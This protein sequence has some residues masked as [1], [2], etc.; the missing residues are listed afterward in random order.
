MVIG[1][2]NMITVQQETSKSTTL[3][4]S[5]GQWLWNSN[6]S[7]ARNIEVYYFGQSCNYVSP[8]A[9]PYNPLLLLSIEITPWATR[10]PP[11]SHQIWNKRTNEQN[12]KLPQKQTFGISR[13]IRS[14][15]CQKFHQQYKSTLHKQCMPSSLA[16]NQNIAKPRYLAFHFYSAGQSI[17]SRLLIN[18]PW[19]H[20]K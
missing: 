10:Q 9:T 15:D 12:L 17:Y 16:T 3:G 13:E 5:Y 4:N 6:C 20:R 8:R 14:N 1:Y 11:I 18:Q 19:Y 7:M 2:G